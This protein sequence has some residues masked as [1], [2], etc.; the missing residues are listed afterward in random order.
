MADPE[1]LFSVEDMA[2][3]QKPEWDFPDLSSLPAKLEGD[4]AIDL[5]TRDDG[6]EEGLGSGWPWDGGY[7][8]GISIAASNW[9]GYFPIRHATGSNLD[10]AKVVSLLNNWLSD[11]TQ[12]KIGANILYDYGWANRIGIKIKGPLHDVQYAGALLDENRWSYSLE[13]LSKEFLNTGKDETLLKK[14]AGAWG[15]DPKGGLWRLPAQFVGEYA[16]T[17]AVL[18]LKLHGILQKKLEAEKLTKIYELEVGLIRLYHD[19]RAKGVRVSE[20]RAV[21]LRDTW[22]QQTK[23]VIAEIKSKTG[24]QVDIWSAES[25]GKALRHENL[26]LTFT[27]KTHKVSVTAE[28]LKEQKHWLTDLVL[29]ARELDKLSETFIESAILRHLHKGRVHTELHPLRSDDGGTVSGRLSSSNPNLQQVPV[30]TEVGNMLRTIFLPEEGE[31]WL[32]CD[33]SQQEPR[34]TVHFAASRTL[35]GKPLTGAEQAVQKYQADPKMSYHKMV[36]ELTGLEY[37]KAKILNLALTYGRGAANT[38]KDL[39]CTVDEAKKFVEQY[40]ERLPYV[41]QLDAVLQ[42]DV[43]KNGYITTILGRK[44]RFTQFEPKNRDLSRGLPPAPYWKAKKNWPGLELK[45]AGLH[46][47]L[48]REIQGSAAD[49]TK[50]AMKMMYDAGYGPNLRLQI[51]DEVCASYLSPDTARAIRDCMRD[52]I[53]LKVPVMVT[54]KTGE[55]W[56]TLEEIE[57]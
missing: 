21:K 2:N 38:A 15:V 35:N 44:C 3:L 11:E 52:A 8:V 9:Q 43:A 47:K 26:Q 39:G 42:G 7:P 5:E 4:I 1:L 50:A 53:K 16:T 40:H 12:K 55:D 18:A 10:Q 14:A 28:W 46:K 41:K 25:L 45:L 48:N 24:F 51:H 23:D 17:D 30:R 34:L 13:S 37:K 33:Y 31:K 54:T 29:K 56:G 19:M 36:A 22:R 27:E 32:S 57:L 49:Q 6:I 20:E